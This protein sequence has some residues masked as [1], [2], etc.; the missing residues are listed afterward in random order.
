MKIKF[1]KAKEGASPSQSQIDEVKEY[2]KRSVG[3]LLTDLLIIYNHWP[4]Q[5]IIRAIIQNKLNEEL[6]K[7]NSLLK[8][9][10]D[11]LKEVIEENNKETRKYNNRMFFLTIAIVFLTIVL[12]AISL[13][14]TNLS[15]G[16]FIIASISIFSLYL[17]E[18]KN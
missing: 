7:N 5:N 1:P 10:V 18:R 16:W 14:N 6:I 8:S 13:K 12:V 3:E 17:N 11:D 2:S 4:K 15:Y 9:S